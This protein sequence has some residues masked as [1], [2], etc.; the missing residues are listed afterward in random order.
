MFERAICSSTEEHTVTLPNR[1]CAVMPVCGTREDIFCNAGKLLRARSCLHARTRQHDH[2]HAP[3]ARFGVVICVQE[4]ASEAAAALQA[5]RDAASSAAAERDGVWRAELDAQR[6]ELQRVQRDAE[7]LRGE[8]ERARREAET[9][10][11][12]LGGARR[13][14]RTLQGELERARHEADALRASLREA[15]GRASALDA[16]EAAALAARAEAAGE[17]AA[18]AALRRVGACHQNIMTVYASC[19]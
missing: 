5:E 4:R 9:L 18:C 19:E 17:R 10:R 6:A 8:L 14:D 1:Q 12:E 13:S 16:A 15:E 2:L 7:A 3:A 11:G